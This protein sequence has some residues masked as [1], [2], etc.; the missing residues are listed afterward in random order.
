MKRKIKGILGFVAIAA[1]AILISVSIDITSAKIAGICDGY[2]VGV[3]ATGRVGSFLVGANGTYV[4]NLLTGPV[5]Q[6]FDFDIIGPA[7]SAGSSMLLSAQRQ[8]LLGEYV[9]NI[10]TIDPNGDDALQ[11]TQAGESGQP[12]H[13]DSPIFSPDGTKIAFAASGDIFIMNADG[14]GKTNLT[15]PW[16]D[17]DRPNSH[18][19]PHFNADGTSLMFDCGF[20]SGN[21][22]S[23]PTICRVDTDGSDYLILRDISSNP[24][25]PKYTE[26]RFSSNPLF[27]YAISN[28]GNNLNF[29]RLVIVPI[30]EFP[31]LPMS[32]D[33]KVSSFDL[34]PD[35]TKI[36]YEARG[37][38][39]PESSQEIF[40]I[41]EDGTGRIRLTNNSTKDSK[42]VF[43]QD[44]LRIAFLRESGSGTDQL[45]IM[46]LDGTNTAGPLAPQ[47][48]NIDVIRSFFLANSPDDTVPDPCD[49]CALNANNDQADADGDGAGDA[50][51]LDDDNDGLPDA[52]DNCP[53]NSNPSQADNEGDGQGDV[54]DPDDD[55]DGVS[56]DSDNCPL[57]A[58]QYRVA[59]SS[60]RTS[61]GSYDIYTMKTDGTAVTRLT[62]SSAIDTHPDFNSDGS[63]IVFTSNRNNSRNEIYV[64]NANGSGV[65]RLTNVAGNNITPEFSPDGTKIT[66]ISS[67]GGGGAQRNV[68]IMNADGTNPLK[69]T[70]NQGFSGTANNPTFNPNDSRIAFDSD[71][72]SAGN[73]NHDIFTINPDGTG[74]LRLTTATGK[75]FDPSFSGDGSKI[76]FLSERNGDTDGEIY[77]M[78]SDGTN[79][80]RLTGNSDRELEPA[81]S[82]D[83][84]KIMFRIAGTVND[85]WE[86][87]S[88]GTGLTRITQN[89]GANEYPSYAPQADSDGDGRGDACDNCAAANPDQT[90]TDMDG[91]GNTCDNCLTVPNTNQADADGDGLGDACDTDFDAQTGTGTNVTVE[92]G[93]AVVTFAGVSVMAQPLLRL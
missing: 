86:I 60:T 75:D 20:D 87:N 74:E 18:N 35:R 28:E 64:M 17:P 37:A 44:G 48:G 50:C 7:N 55:N 57:T 25:A 68:W 85:L 31:G 71:R 89:Q 63:R 39:D 49:N 46:N 66:F 81:L 23:S 88:D 77:I 54:C 11:L 76:A 14:S 26:A 15:G 42:P 93:N 79:Q 83:G 80:I 91:V 72:G 58:N 21:V 4:K 22:E 84:S 38:A 12:H 32:E 36:V 3:N 62:T 69:L 16:Q 40:L 52:S 30:V 5:N 9:T 41:N 90:D 73:A 92:T 82:P 47:T 10:F 8:N 70:T 78:N 53:L 19:Y 27:F 2:V 1:T 6:E 13:F 24:D 56:D 67:Q 34:S 45:Y 51:D 43:S 61:G 29:D 33:D 59:I 65:T